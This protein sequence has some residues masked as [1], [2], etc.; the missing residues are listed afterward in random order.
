[1]L[2]TKRHVDEEATEQLIR[3]EIHGPG[4]LA[5]YRNIWHALRLR[6]GVHVS[7][8]MVARMMKEIDPEGVELRKSRRLTRRRY[9]SL[10]PSFCW[11]LDGKYCMLRWLRIVL[12]KF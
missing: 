6:H 5:G 2:S 1:M 9:T 10:G 11:H 3:R 12:R 8:K 7:Q 4:R